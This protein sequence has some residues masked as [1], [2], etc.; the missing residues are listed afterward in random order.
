MKE[1]YSIR[2]DKQDHDIVTKM[3]EDVGLTFSSGIGLLLAL[4]V[5]RK[6]LPFEVPK[7]DSVSKCKN[8]KGGG[9]P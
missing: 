9:K 4:I 1:S 6:E 3:F 7:M 5:K 8:A 2:L